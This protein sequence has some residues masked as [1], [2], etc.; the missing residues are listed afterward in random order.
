MDEMLEFKYKTLLRTILGG[1]KYR[2]YS[3]FL[4]VDNDDEVFMVIK[5][6]EPELYA[7]KYEELKQKEETC[8]ES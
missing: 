8:S 3:S 6:L 7:A 5:I 4:G 2:T 1:A